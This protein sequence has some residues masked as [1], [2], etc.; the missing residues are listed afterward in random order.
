MNDVIKVHDL[1]AIGRYAKSIQQF[2]KEVEAAASETERQFNSKTGNG[3]DEA[4]ALV[5]FFERLNILQNLVFHRYP[6]YMENFASSVSHFESSVSGAGFDKEAWTSGSGMQD[7]VKKLTD[8]GSDSQLYAIKDTIKHLQELFDRA[9]SALG[10]ENESLEATKQA[11]EGGLAS[12]KDSRQKTHNQIQTSHDTFNAT[13]FEV[14]SDLMGMSKDIEEAEAKLAVAPD[15]VLASIVNKTFTSDKAY[16]LDAVQTKADAEIMTVILSEGDD[17]KEFFTKLANVNMKDSSLEVSQVIVER[18]MFEVNHPGK[19]GEVPNLAIFMEALTQRDKESVKDYSLRLSAGAKATADGYK[20]QVDDLVP[21]FPP[22]GSPAKAYDEYFKKKNSPKIQKAVVALNNK[23]EWYEKLDS[24][25]MYAALNDMGVGK[26]ITLS[27]SNK[28]GGQDTVSIANK[29]SFKKDNFKLTKGSEGKGFSFSVITNFVGETKVKADL[30]D[31]KTPLNIQGNEDKIIE[32]NEEK[33]ML[34]PRTV[35]NTMKDLAKLY[36]PAGVLIGI[37]EAG[38]SEDKDIKKLIDSGE[39]ISSSDIWDDTSVD[40]YTK[41]AE[42]AVNIAKNIYDYFDKKE[43]YDN[44]IKVLKND[45]EAEFWQYGGTSFKHEGPKSNIKYVS[46]SYDVEAY[47]KQRDLEK[48]GLRTY[49]AET[50]VKNGEDP[51]NTLKNF[52]ESI[53]KSKTNKVYTND[54]KNLLSGRSK[55]SVDQIGFDDMY[56]GIKEAE[57]RITPPTSV[58]DGANQTIEQFQNNPTYFTRD[59]YGKWSYLDY[60]TGVGQ[61]GGK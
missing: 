37:V 34:F 43:A 28:N 1:P 6:K 53:N 56:N 38:M 41:K 19:N 10:I 9:T 13:L 35:A 54:I 2:S 60:V 5:A 47:L 29:S 20:V 45:S 3:N 24:L 59:S 36:P 44:E 57:S 40:K 15:V 14:M 26:P 51:Y 32:L 46:P 8:E 7:L 25:F 55:Y 31:E 23:V 30:I 50:A 16:Y 49:I 58:G 27:V 12:S 42:G 21:E 22:Q 4:L 48:N 18:L 52:D 33:S 17:K 61:G 11:A 39:A